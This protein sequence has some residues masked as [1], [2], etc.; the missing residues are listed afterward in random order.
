[1][2]DLT[3]ASPHGANWKGSPGHGCVPLHRTML[4]LDIAN[5]TARANP[6]KG[7]FRR[8]MY[9]LLDEAMRASGIADQH[10][11]PP[12]DRG[13]GALV[14]FHPADQVPKTLLLS[15]LLPALEHLL[16]EH[17]EHHPEQA[18]Q[19]RA[20]AHAGEVHYDRWG[21][22]GDDLD[23][24]CR[25]LDAPA[26]KRVLASAAEPMA[27]V[28]SDHLYRSIVRHGYADIDGGR[29]TPLVN[30]DVAGTAHTGWVP[31]TRAAPRPLSV[32]GGTQ[33]AGDRPS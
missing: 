5:S 24:V 13:D 12:I 22:Y 17:N 31:A 33:T 30:V 2:T 6:A 26:L 3:I 28:V 10:H 14:L 1:M 16:T 9:D 15:R 18:F 23:L 32:A 7:R 11:D 20:A 4:V 21:P 27:L 8:V 25:L 29:F 19:L